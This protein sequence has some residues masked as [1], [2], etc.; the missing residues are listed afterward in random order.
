[1]APMCQI[2]RVKVHGSCCSVRGV[3]RLGGVDFMLKGQKKKM[4]GANQPVLLMN[5][6]AKGMT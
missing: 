2:N 6:V 3:D 4:Y 5:L 1:M